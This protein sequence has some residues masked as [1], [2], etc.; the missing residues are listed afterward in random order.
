MQLIY[1]VIADINGA[2]EKILRELIEK[3]EGRPAIL[4]DAKNLVLAS[5]PP[6]FDAHR[7]RVIYRD[8]QLGDIQVD[9][10]GMVVRFIP[11]VE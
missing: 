1:N 6:H 9:M 4:Q 11:I 8:V 3:V 10:V 2:K 5:F 7:E